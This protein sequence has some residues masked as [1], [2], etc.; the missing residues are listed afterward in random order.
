MRG[1]MTEIAVPIDLRDRLTEAAG[2]LGMLPW[3]LIDK[4]LRDFLWAEQVAEAK[5]A[6]ANT[7]AEEWADYTDEFEDIERAF[8]PQH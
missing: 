4:L 3:G 8:G 5:R 7:S 1:D 6:M 2:D